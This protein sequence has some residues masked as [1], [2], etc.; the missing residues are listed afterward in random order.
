MSR[1]NLRPKEQAEVSRPTGQAGMS[2]TQTTSSKSQT[3]DDIIAQANAGVGATQ[4][5]RLTHDYIMGQTTTDSRL[6]AVINSLEVASMGSEALGVIA[7][8]AWALLGHEKVWQGKF[9][10]AKDAKAALETPQLTAIRRM[11]SQGGQRK[12]RAISR[13]Q[14]S[15]PG[16][17]DDQHLMDMGEH[18]LEAVSRA[19]GRY[20]YSEARSF[21]LKLRNRRLRQGL[22]GRSAVRDVSTGDWKQMLLLRTDTE[23]QTLLQELALSAAERQ[24]FNVTDQGQLLILHA[25]GRVSA[26]TRNQRRRYRNQ[27]RRATGLER[28]A[29]SDPDDGSD[30]P[31]MPKDRDGKS[32]NLRDVA[33]E[34]ESVNDDP[35]D[36]SDAKSDD[37]NAEASDT[38]DTD[39]TL[40]SGTENA[41]MDD[42]SS[43]GNETDSTYVNAEPDVFRF[44]GG[45]WVICDGVQCAQG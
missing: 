23:K 9:Q 1:Y 10:S 18:H 27:V 43:S 14:S 5:Q 32:G 31:A 33:G 44:E 3:I 4:I 21:L 25:P 28:E 36:T 15:W 29:S 6:A 39:D 30:A 20:L 7:V 45:R 37:A 12:S 13:I 38:N 17:I 26:Q 22:G 40:I 41:E 11:F 34:G 8:E 2:L 19:A 16:V 24:K 42:V 35:Q